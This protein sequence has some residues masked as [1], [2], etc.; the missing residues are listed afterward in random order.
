MPTQRWNVDVDGQEHVVETQHSRWTNAG[1]VKV[2]GRVV[3]A[4]GFT[5]NLTQKRF[6]IGSKAAMIRWAGVV[7]ARCDLF[8]D[9]W[10]IPR[11]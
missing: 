3:D 10:E 11:S 2:D 9:G 6:S 8:V 4:W 1:E 7:S 5:M